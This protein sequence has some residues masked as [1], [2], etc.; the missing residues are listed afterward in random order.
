[1]TAG[2]LQFQI[3]S[4]GGISIT[5]SPLL[6]QVPSYDFTP[7]NF[8]LLLDGGSVSLVIAR[9]LVLT[10]VSQNNIAGLAPIDITASIIQF[11]V[12]VMI[13]PFYNN[14][15][16]TDIS[17][18]VI[19]VPP[20]FTAKLKQSGVVLC[21]TELA[22]TQSGIAVPG[23]GISSTV[24]QFYQFLWL[25][26]Y[27]YPPTGNIF[28]DYQKELSLDLVATI[29]L[30]IASA[31]GNSMPN[32]YAYTFTTFDNSPSPTVYKQPNRFNAPDV[33]TQSLVIL[34][35]DVTPGQ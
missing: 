11:N 34:V 19:P 22:V 3:P 1:M 2:N 6:G 20:K 24:S 31:D 33:F 4:G 5:N 32:L 28:I 21:S 13:S 14:V 17:N 27:F 26:G 12:I 8:S 7:A 15:I 23:N 16:N 35:G 10:P 25:E 18:S 29:N 30:P 9:D